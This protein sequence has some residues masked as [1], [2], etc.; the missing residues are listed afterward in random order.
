MDIT[1]TLLVN[2]TCVCLDKGNGERMFYPV[3]GQLNPTCPACPQYETQDGRPVQGEIKFPVLYPR[4]GIYNLTA[5]AS[6]GEW[7]QVADLSVSV[8]DKPP[9]RYTFPVAQF[10]D[11]RSTDAT[12]PAAF[13]AANG[14]TPT[15]TG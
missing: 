9:P 7:S 5:M 11:P 10:E 14:Y 2:E 8:P 6:F 4:S 15:A 13:P 12:Q 1:F 3:L